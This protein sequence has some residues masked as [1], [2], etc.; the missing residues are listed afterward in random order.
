MI[1]PFQKDIYK[2]LYQNSDIVIFPADKNSGVV[3]LQ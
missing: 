3:I 2:L 1:Y